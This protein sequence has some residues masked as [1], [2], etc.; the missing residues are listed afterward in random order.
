VIYKKGDK[1]GLKKR[2][3]K[4]SLY[5]LFWAAIGLLYPPACG[6]CGKKGTEWCDDCRGSIILLPELKCELC[7]LPQPKKGACNSC[8]K[9]QPAYQAMRSW[10]VFEGP[11]RK[12]LH[13]LKYRQDL[14]LGD[15]LAAAMLDYV[16]CLAWN[17]D[18]VVPV[19]LGKKRFRERGYNQVSLIA[20]PLAL[21]KGWKYQPL[22]LKR[23]IET[24]SQVGLSAE[25]RKA[26]VHNAFVADAK[27][28]VGKSVLVL[29]D[30]STTGATL[31]SCAEALIRSGARQVY[32]LSI[33]RALPRHG[34]KTV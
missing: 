25:E 9:E 19:P 26:N 18:L 23:A 32:A 12:A 20:W 5:R 1:D 34:L 22:S 24:K 30:V 16:D 6:G 2:P 3:I 8:Q 10:V 21:A 15:I 33:A 7:G 14:G 11:V 28:V 13:R 17:I 4:Y 31:N 29:D 27:K